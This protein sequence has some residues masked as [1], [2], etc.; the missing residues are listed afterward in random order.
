MGRRIRTIRTL[1]IESLDWKYSDRLIPLNNTRNHNLHSDA[2]LVASRDGISAIYVP[3]TDA[4]RDR[5]DPM[6][7]AIARSH[8]LILRAL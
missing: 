5:G 4:D 7:T 8:I 3:L 6:P 2:H 1:F